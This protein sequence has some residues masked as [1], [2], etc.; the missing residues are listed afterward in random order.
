MCWAPEP[1]HDHGQEEAEDASVY[2]LDYIER[3]LNQIH[4]SNLLHK[5]F[6]DTPKH[7]LNHEDSVLSLVWVAVAKSIKKCL[8]LLNHL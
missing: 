3:D 5:T 2:A 6:S 8:N 4:Y 7:C 1:P